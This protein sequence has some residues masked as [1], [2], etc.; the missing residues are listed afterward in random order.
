[1]QIGDKV[2]CTRVPQPLIGRHNPNEGIIIFLFGKRK[3]YEYAVVD[4]INGDY[5]MGNIEDLKVISE[6]ND[7]LKNML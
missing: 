5:W 1:M 6:S 4:L 7:I 3:G 2:K